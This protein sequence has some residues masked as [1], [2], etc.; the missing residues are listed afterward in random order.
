MLRI[1]WIQKVSNEKFPKRVG[2]M[3][4]LMQN[5]KQ[6]KVECLGHVLR[7]DRYHLLQLIIMGKIQGKRHVGR[8]KKSW[9]RNVREWTGIT[10]AEELLHLAQDETRFRKLTANLQ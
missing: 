1:S 7:H 9:L 5:I 3:K 4:K 2:M 8:R 6:P 10:T